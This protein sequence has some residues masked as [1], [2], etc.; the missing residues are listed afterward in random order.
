MAKTYKVN[1]SSFVTNTLFNDAMYFEL[2]NDNKPNVGGLVNK[3]IPTLLYNRKARRNEIENIL[4]NEYNRQDSENI[5]TAVNTIIDRVYFNDIELNNLEEQLWIRPNAISKTAFDEIENS[6][7]L[8]TAQ[9]VTEYIRGLLNE[10]VRFPQYKRE[11]F[12]FSEELNI[13]DTACNTR[14]VLHFKNKLTKESY[15]A[16]AFG[17]FYGYLYD[18]TNYCVIYDLKNNKIKSI[19]LHLIENIFAIK[20]KY[21]PSEKLIEL[22]QDYCDNH[23]FNEEISVE[24]D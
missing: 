6:E 1:V 13:F 17:Y 5:Y 21:K 18:L 3:L 14:Q 9:S 2:I 4:K 22:L 12:A 10:Y 7:V 11:S 20:Q 16:F 24:E 23:K 19:P 15:K 8:I